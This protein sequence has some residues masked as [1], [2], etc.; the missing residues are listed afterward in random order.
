MSAVLGGFSING[1]LIIIGTSDEPL[2]V[3]PSLML[4]DRRSIVGWSNES[5]ID[6][7]DTCN[8]NMVTIIPICIVKKRLE[9]LYRS[10]RKKSFDEV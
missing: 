7:H 5:S 9:N 10:I 6:L 2:E 3:Y 1:K 8:I 4:P